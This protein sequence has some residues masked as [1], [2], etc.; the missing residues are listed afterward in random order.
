MKHLVFLLLFLFTAPLFAQ[1]ELLPGPRGKYVRFLLCHDG[2]TYAATGGGVCI[3]HDHGSHWAFSN[4]GLT[5]LDTKALARIGDT[6][7]VSTDENVFRTTDGGQSW[8]PCGEELQGF[9][10]K[11]I[12]AHNGTLFVGT[13]LRGIWRSTD[14]GASWQHVSDGFPVDYAYYLAAHGNYVFASTYL[15]GCYRSSDNGEHWESC[16]TGLTET[17]GISIYAFGNRLFMST[18]S[19]NLFISDDDGAHWTSSSGLPSIKAF[20]SWQDTLYAASFGQGI[21]YSTDNGNNW[22]HPATIPNA[23]SLWSI[24]VD[25]SNVYLGL[26]NGAVAASDHIG[27]NGHICDMDPFNATIG[28]LSFWGN[29]LIATSHGSNL[30]YTDNLGANWTSGN[31]GTVEIRSILIHNN[32]VLVG[33]DMLGAFR[34]TNGGSS[35]SDANNGLTTNWIQC[36]AATNSQIYAGSGNAG[37]F[38]ST[39]DGQSWQS[40]GLPEFEIRSMATSNLGLYAATDHGLYFLPNGSNSWQPIGSEEVGGQ[41]TAVAHIH[42][43]LWVGTRDRGLF[44]YDEAGDRWGSCPG[45]E[46]EPVRCVLASEQGFVVAGLEHGR[47]AQINLSDASAS[48]L[49]NLNIDYPILTVAEG[50]DHQLYFGTPVGIFRCP[51]F[52]NVGIPVCSQTT[53]SCIAPNPCYG[54][55]VVSAPDGGAEISVINAIGQ[56]IAT[57]QTCD[58][59]CEVKGLMPGIYLVRIKSKQGTEVHKLIVGGSR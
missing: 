2:T 48:A 30:F 33:T 54:Q 52:E 49:G 44:Y 53:S 28:G 10:C 45:Y 23:T 6:I 18:L 47:W 4:S 35:F 22:N 57:Y 25:E 34:S 17:T 38:V 43:S 46:N 51:P 14:R 11:H 58:A 42:D 37:V 12:L 15:Q 27:A 50:P 13:Y 31:V 41:P 9:Y 24:A 8:E 20:C 55:T 26:D 29:R 36:F 5:S 21:Y 19:G 3:S 1:L 59:I 40:A 56:T 16:N 32:T 7:F 39:N